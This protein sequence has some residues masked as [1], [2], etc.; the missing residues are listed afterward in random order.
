[1]EVAMRRSFL[2]AACALILLSHPA[3][4]RADP[5]VQVR[6]YHII[7]AGQN[8]APFTQ[9]VFDRFNPQH[10]ELFNVEFSFQL[11]LQSLS[12]DYENRD[13]NPIT[14]NIQIAAGTNYVGAGLVDEHGS[15]PIDAIN[16]FQEDVNFGPFDGA[17]DFTG[18]D[19]FN[20]GQVTPL[21]TGSVAT[22]VSFLPYI[23]T[24][25]VP[26]QIVA[27]YGTGTTQSIGVRLNS[28]EM[29]GIV[30]LRYNSPIPEPSTLF[31]SGSGFLLLWLAY[32]RRA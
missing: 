16:V 7:L 20:F 15:A 13:M 14:A 24:G 6:D 11:T 12:I 23:G 32:R 8:P 17:S 5:I 27:F 9:I 4:L 3:W 21:T 1:M 31:L 26:L 18:A 22:P 25:S 30:T 2:P 19:A 28:A 10:G 29:T